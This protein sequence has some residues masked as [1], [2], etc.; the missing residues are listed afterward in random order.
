[1]RIAAHGAVTFTRPGYWYNVSRLMPNARATWA[2]C[3]PAPMRRFT[4]AI[5]A[6]VSDFL[7]PRYT[8][9]CLRQGNAFALAL[10]EQGAFEFP[11]KRP[12]PTA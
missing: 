1:M 12:S 11:Q 9:R 3:S 5:C 2:F 4:S 6:L 7:R 10:A 8:P